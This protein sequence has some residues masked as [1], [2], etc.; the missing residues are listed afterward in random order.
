M[1]RYFRTPSM[2]P[3]RVAAVAAT[4]ARVVGRPVGQI[5]TEYCFYIEIEEA[6]GTEGAAG[7]AA[8]GPLT[9]HDPPFSSTCSRRPSSPSSSAPRASWTGA[10][11]RSSSTGRG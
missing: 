6:S 5:G 10:S 11:R 9:A 4:A 7:A 1:L 3:T 2:T 8:A